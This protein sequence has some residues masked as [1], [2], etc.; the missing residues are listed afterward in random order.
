MWEAM[1]NTTYIHFG[2]RKGLRTEPLRVLGISIFVCVYILKMGW[3][4]RVAGLGER[5][6]HTGF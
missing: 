4:G 1:S 3:A 5:R 2:L 6:V